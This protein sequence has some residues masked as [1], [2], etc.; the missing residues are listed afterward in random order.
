MIYEVKVYDRAGRL[1]KVIPGSALSW[2][3]EDGDGSNIRT[4]KYFEI[5]CE[6]CGNMLKVRS[7]GQATCNKKPCKNR[8]QD[9]L[10]RIL[11]RSIVFMLVLLAGCASSPPPGELP[12]KCAEIVKEG[13]KVHCLSIRKIDC[14]AD[15]DTCMKICLYETNDGRLFNRSYHID[16]GICP[17]GGG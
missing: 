14:F 9:K 5:I 16:P 3:H 10:A 13:D 11:Q 15:P 6:V 12:A 2:H 7:E 8:R 17:S 4:T 1:K